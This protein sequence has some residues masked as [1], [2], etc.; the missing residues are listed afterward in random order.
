VADAM[1]LRRTLGWNP[2]YSTLDSI[3]STAW[4]WKQ[5]HPHGYPEIEGDAARQG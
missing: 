4:I 5:A 3:L 1:K 2:R